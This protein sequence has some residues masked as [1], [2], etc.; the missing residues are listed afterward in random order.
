M[1]FRICYC[2]RAFNCKNVLGQVVNIAL[3]QVVT[4][5]TTLGLINVLIY[6]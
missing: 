5:V 1:K 2:P 3:G 6:N 4:T